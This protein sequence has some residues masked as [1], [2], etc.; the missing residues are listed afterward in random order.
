MN[1]SSP[2]CIPLFWSFLITLTETSRTM[3]NRNG[4]HE[5]TFSCLWFYRK[6]IYFFLHLNL[7]CLWF[8]Y[9]VLLLCELRYPK[10]LQDFY[11]EWVLNFVKGFFLPVMKKK[12]CFCLSLYKWIYIYSIIPDLWVEA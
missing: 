6:S 1:S 12:S 5:S 7:C 3:L 2:N 11:P 8:C 4:Q 9:K 10:S